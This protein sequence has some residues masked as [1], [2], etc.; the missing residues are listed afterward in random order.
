VIVFSVTDKESFEKIPSFY[1][2]I[3]KYRK[4]KPQFLV[5]LDLTCFD[6]VVLPVLMPF[7]YCSQT[8]VGTKKDISDQRQVKQQEAELLAKKY[9][10][11]YVETSLKDDDDSARLI[12]EGLIKKIWKTGMYPQRFYGATK[13][14]RGGSRCLLS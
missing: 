11:A 4:D 6:C 12:V 2:H 7:S 13:A 1:E 3:K 14:H 5:R 10:A 8:L 9:D